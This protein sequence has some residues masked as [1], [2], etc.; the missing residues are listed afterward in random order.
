MEAVRQHSTLIVRV[1]TR[2]YTKSD[3]WLATD[4]LFFDENKQL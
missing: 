3:N 2:Y 1:C 4:H